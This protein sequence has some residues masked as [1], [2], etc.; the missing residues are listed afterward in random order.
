MPVLPRRPRGDRV[1][2]YTHGRKS[3]RDGPAV[4]SVKVPDHVV[5]RLIPRERICELKGDPLRSRMIGDAQGYQPSPLVPQDG[6][7]KQQPK[8]DGRHDQEV[9]RADACRMIVQKGLPGLVCPA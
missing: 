8:A 9:H 4:A 2:A 6:Q 3:L 1:I 7:D 5:R